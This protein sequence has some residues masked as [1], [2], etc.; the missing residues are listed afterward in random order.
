MDAELRAG[1]LEGQFRLVGDLDVSTVSA[2]WRQGREL[3]DSSPQL[4]ID[5]SE[6]SKSDSAGLALLIEWTRRARGGHQEIRFENIPDQ[7]LAIARVSGLDNVLP[8]FRTP[9]AERSR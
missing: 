7:M 5:L 6:V 4:N 3:F 8:F 2:V 9:S 1:N